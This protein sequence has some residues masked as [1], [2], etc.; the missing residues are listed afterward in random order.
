MKRRWI[1]SWLVFGALAVAFG[2]C[3]GC[4]DG[5]A[6]VDGGNDAPSGDAPFPLCDPVLQTGC[7]PDE[8]CTW[9]WVTDGSEPWDGRYDCAAD[10][11]VAVGDDCERVEEGTDD[12]A[13][14][15]FCFGP[16]DGT[17][18]CEAFC[19]MVPNSC[20]N[21]YACGLFAGLTDA[22][23]TVGL[24]SFLC[25]PIEQDDCPRADEAC[26]F[27]A[28]TGQPRLRTDTA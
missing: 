14:G 2:G 21:N 3:G 25:D 28:I 5:N 27:N 8:K 26:H 4:G 22:L 23:P 18:R 19:T 20:P 15:S 9:V 6:D 11:S 12:C 24:C 1:A 13:A 7:G 17:G 10:G 16:G